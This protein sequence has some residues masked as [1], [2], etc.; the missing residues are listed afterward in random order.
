RGL[1]EGTPR[2]TAAAPHRHGH[3]RHPAVG[4][5]HHRLLCRRRA[6]R[7]H[8]DPDRGDPVVPPRKAPHMTDLRITGLV[9]SYGASARVLD[10]LDLSVP[11]GRLAA[12]LGP[13][14]CGKTTLLRIVAG[15]LRAD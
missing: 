6:V 9:K 8:A 10:G 5:D 13:S 12:V 11:A 15:F 1:H 3:P 7:R 2:H 14:G 4:R